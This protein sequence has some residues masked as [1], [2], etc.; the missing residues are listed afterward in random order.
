LNC[1]RRGTRPLLDALDH[2]FSSIETDI[3]LV[4][5][6][7][8]VGHNEADLEPGLTLQ[9]LYLDPLREIAAEHPPA[10]PIT[11]LIG[12]KTEGEATYRA[13]SAVLS[14][15]ADILAAVR[16]GVRIPGAVIAVVSGNRPKAAIAA[17]NPRRAFYDGR[18]TD[19]ESGL[20]PDVMPLV[21]D[22]WTRHFTWTGA[23]EVPADELERL[24]SLVTAVH[25]RGCELRFWGTP[26]RPGPERDALW[27]VLFSAGVDLINTDDLTGF[28]LFLESTDV[29]T[30][31]E[32]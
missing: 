20:S 12:I 14:G 30:A 13:L 28:K 16:D 24:K 32:R 17:D 31:T 8:L 19:L 22:N 5:G 25:A 9:N 7:L 21:S 29:L 3:W 18:L 2:G 27:G 23:G 1:L 4:A 10:E 11:L 6:E 26:D 15:Y